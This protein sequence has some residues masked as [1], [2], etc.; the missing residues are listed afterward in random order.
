MLD[1]TR[2]DLVAELTWVPGTEAEFAV[3]LGGRV[4]YPMRLVTRRLSQAAADC[5]CRKA[6]KKARRQ[7]KTCT[8]A[9]LFLLG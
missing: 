7:G 6:R 2:L 3:K 9:Y 8:K 1:D 5:R 4:K